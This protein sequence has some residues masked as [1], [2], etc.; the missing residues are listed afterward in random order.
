[1]KK[2]TSAKVLN[3]PLVNTRDEHYSEI[4]EEWLVEARD[5]YISRLQNV[6]EVAIHM[7]VKV[8]KLIKVCLTSFHS[9]K[10]SYPD[11][12]LFHICDS[13]IS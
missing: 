5:V 6:L 12:H 3:Y 2:A 7:L 10:L 4:I 11:Y 1:M 13:K 9:I 8:M